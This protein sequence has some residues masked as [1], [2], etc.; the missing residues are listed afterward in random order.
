MNFDALCVFCLSISL[1]NFFQIHYYY[2]NCLSDYT[3]ASRTPNLKSH[4]VNK[5]S[6]K[7]VHSFITESIPTFGESIPLLLLL[8]TLISKFVNSSRAK[9]ERENC[10][11]IQKNTSL[12]R[13]YLLQKLFEIGFFA[14]LLL[15]LRTL[16]V[17]LM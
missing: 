16:T 2:C 9:S 11:A 17:R 1:T 5:S 10:K 12:L 3:L 8:P 15:L 4:D 13:T 7:T 6:F 14:H